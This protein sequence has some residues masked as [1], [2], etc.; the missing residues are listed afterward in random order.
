MKR[1]Q[2]VQKALK[3]YKIDALV[4]QNPVD[5]FYL[6]GVELSLGTLVI[7]EK[8]ARLFV[9]G[10]Y[11]EKCKANC[12]VDVGNL[13]QQ[14]IDAYC[15]K[16]KAIGFDADSTSYQAYTVLSKAN[17]HLVPL[18][19]PIEKI[20]AVKEAS[21]IKAMERAG[22][23]CMK[24]FDFLCTQLKTGVTE[25]ALARALEIFWLSNGGEKLA[26]DPIIAFGKNSSMPHY[27]A[28]DTKLCAGDIVLIDIGVMVDGYASDITRIVFYG[29]PKAKLLEI[30]DIV[31]KAKDT[32][33]EACCPGIEAS[34]LYKVAAKVIEKAGYKEA[35]LHGLGHGIGLNVHEYP[36]LR[37]T[38]TDAPLQASMAVTLEPG[39]YLPGIGGVRLE[40]TVL[41]TKTGC[42]AITTA[43]EEKIIMSPSV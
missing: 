1:I 34:D 20:R 25:K 14:D 36:I 11:I 10:R 37:A 13:L 17:S 19:K 28:Q 21:E 9:D 35:F 30:Y 27:R 8:S 3:S 16:H 43:P 40:D 4:V 26:F 22:K 41:V 6:T 29:K 7:S 38:V 39:I 24:G 18:S 42:R 23:L 12:A 31:K 2:K 33:F 15:K 32:A 5:L